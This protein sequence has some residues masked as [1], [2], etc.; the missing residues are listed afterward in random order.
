MG[1]VKKGKVSDNQKHIT[2]KDYSEIIKA[3]FEKMSRNQVISPLL[4]EADQI[5]NE[6][7]QQH[8]KYLSLEPGEKPM[9]M[10]DVKV[11]IWGRLTG[12][13]VTDRNVYY[14]C[15]KITFRKKR[16]KVALSDLNEISLG[17]IVFDGTTYLGHRLSLNGNVVG[18]LVLGRGITFD[19]KLVENLE[20]LFKAMV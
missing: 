18:S 10:V 7:L 11:A 5:T 12:L 6:K 20:T 15:M 3:T 14:Q 13:L 17:D 9:F 16:G 2:M 8:A 19:D 1:L 4:L